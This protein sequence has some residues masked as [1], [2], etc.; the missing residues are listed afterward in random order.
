MFELHPYVLEQAGL[1]PALR[2]AAQRAARRGGF[3]VHFELD[4]PQR[5]RDEL[6]LYGAARELLSNAAQHSEARNVTVE[7]TTQNGT[8]L[9]GVA[10]DGRGFDPAVLP[11]RLAE[12][13]VCLQSQ[14]ERIE[15]AGGRLD[16]RS[17]P[18]EGTAV[19]VRL[20]V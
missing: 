19:E 17:S 14:R 3:Q 12:G 1:G 5:H 2:A 20:P 6:L 15:S 9:L 7:L 10:D 8:L 4:Y 11:E 16:L 18:G 13:H